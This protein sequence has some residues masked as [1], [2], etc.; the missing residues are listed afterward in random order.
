[1]YNLSQPTTYKMCIQLTHWWR[2][3]HSFPQDNTHTYWFGL[4]ELLHCIRENFNLN[5]Y[6]GNLILSYWPTLRP[7]LRS[8]W[9]RGDHKHWTVVGFTCGGTIIA[10]QHGQRSSSSSSSSSSMKS[11]EHLH[12]E[13]RRRLAAAI[14][15]HIGGQCS[16][17]E[18]LE[19]AWKQE[20][21]SSK[22]SRSGKQPGPIDWQQHHQQQA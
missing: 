18:G 22:E 19:A 9:M 7:T 21:G 20:V 5:K 6:N 4:I 10:R 12:P 16:H 2:Q 1:M 17:S 3:K 14:N 15:T 11:Q 13:W 8:W